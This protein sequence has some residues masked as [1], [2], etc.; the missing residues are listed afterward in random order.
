MSSPSSSLDE[1]DYVLISSEDWT[2]DHVWIP[3]SPVACQLIDGGSAVVFNLT[4]VDE[5]NYFAAN[6]HGQFIIESEPWNWRRQPKEIKCPWVAEETQEISISDKSFIFELQEPGP[7]GLT[8][9]RKFVAYF[10][11]DMSVEINSDGL[12]EFQ[13]VGGGTFSGHMQLVYAGTSAPKDFTMANKLHKYAGVFSYKPK[14]RF[15]VENDVGYI[16]YDWNKRGD[17]FFGQ[18]PSQDLLMVALP[19]HEKQLEEAA[20][21]EDLPWGFKGYVGDRWILQEELPKSTL[22]PD[23]DAVARIKADPT[24]LNEILS[25]IEKDAAFETLVEDCTREG[26]QSYW[27]GKSIG[28]V[29]RLATI[30]RAFETDHYED[31]DES[32]R[33]CLD[34]WLGRIGGLTIENTFRYDTVWGGLYMRSA[35]LDEEIFPWTNFGFVSYADHHFHL[36]YWMYAIA[37][38]ATY[39]P[40]WANNEENRIRITALARDVGSPSKKDI[41]FPTVRQKDWYFG[42]S[43]ATG[44]GGGARQEESASE[45]INCYHA[46]GALGAAMNDPVMESMGRLM[47]ATE[48]RATRFYWT[49]RD[50]NQHIFPEPILKYG[51]LGQ[52]QEDG[53]FYYTLNWACDPDQFPQRHA[54]IVGIQ[55]I[56]I[57]SISHWYVDQEWANNVYDICSWAIDPLSAPGGDMI[58]Q[59]WDTSAPV[60][61]KWGAFCQTI[62]SK[63][64]ADSQTAAAAYT[65]ALD[66]S[67][68][69]PGTGLASNLLFIY[70]ST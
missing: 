43:W 44:I 17:D 13:P 21:A 57:M 33:T 38:Y 5:V 31:L 12:F 30:S 27:A 16:S 64:D 9:T 37:Y 6:V 45:A 36:G 51:V 28:M 60:S 52:L 4:A 26:P 56:P 23:M 22:E 63:R 14:T 41:Y 59:Q 68:L 25:G 1:I 66:T 50:D 62:M 53:I 3:C 47:L 2:G 20:V 69:E 32:L 49:V 39:Y 61:T 29:T 40:E 70:E 55:L 65:V 8:D 18:N 7:L 24:K 15:C 35:K 19:H 34:L 11:E 42:S 67:D 54:C 10:E 58:D 46:L 48:L